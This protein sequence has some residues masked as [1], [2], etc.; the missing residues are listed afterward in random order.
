MKICVL[1]LGYVGLPLSI[2]LAKNFKVTGYDYNLKKIK[3]I[4][5]KKDYTGE[6]NKKKIGNI[7]LY[8][9]NQKSELKNYN[10]YIIC[11]PTPILKDKTPDLKYV[12]KSCILI[13][14][15]IKNSK[16]KPIVILEST[17][18]PGFSEEVCV[19]IIEKYSN[20]KFNK[21]FYFGYSP[22]RINPGKSKYKL[23]N[24]TKIISASNLS[25]L[26][27]LKKIYKTVVKKV[28]IAPNIKI[29]EA[30]KV[31]EN[32]QRDINIALMNE[33]SMIF[34]KINIDTKEVLK[35]ASTKWN[36]AYYEPGLVGGHC[37][38]IDPYYMAYL[39]K[40]IGIKKNYMILSGRK[41]NE[42]MKE[43]ILENLLKLLK[44]KGIKFKISKILILGYAFKENCNDVRNSKVIEIFKYLRKK[45]KKI[46]LYD[47][48]VKDNGE[49]LSYKKNILKRLNYNKKYDVVVLAVKHDIFKKMNIKRILSLCNHHKLFV[50][51]K[52]IFDKKYSVFRL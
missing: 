51:L 6:V 8:A 11:V 14:N 38:G 3:Q 50:D 15:S 28:Y 2:S 4:K 22:E 33:L 46:D 7:N 9:T 17:V 30:A 41:T 1:G 29:A 26:K 39:T 45:V 52:S 16:L 19:P 27:K 47:P 5:K 13:G 31:I 25:S 21:E 42:N 34:N 37:I 12:K 20:L 18:Y 32:I 24:T 43:F 49:L 44:S 23:Y 36:F 10:I 35:A 48:I 40:K